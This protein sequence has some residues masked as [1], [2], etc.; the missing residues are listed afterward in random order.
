VDTFG[1][2]QQEAFI[3]V[4]ANLLQVNSD[5]VAIISVYNLASTR[6]RLLQDGVDILFGAEVADVQAAGA[7]ESTVALLGNNSTA[8]VQALFN[9]GLEHVGVDSVAVLSSPPPPSSTTIFRCAP[10]PSI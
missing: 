6:R 7:V 1:D 9:E 8:F 2:T 10:R 5:A 4:T 3:S